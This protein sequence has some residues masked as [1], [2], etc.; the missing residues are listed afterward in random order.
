MQVLVK[1]NNE[2]LFNKVMSFCLRSV[3]KSDFG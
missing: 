3:N 2:N 1:N